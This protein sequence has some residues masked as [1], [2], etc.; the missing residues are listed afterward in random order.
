MISSL[1]EDFIKEKRYL[2]NL[3]ER[4]LTSYRT[5]MFRRWIRHVGGM[6][7]Q[8]GINQFVIKMREEGLAISTC[9]ITIRSLNS[10]LS[11]LHRNDH[12]PQNLKVKQ[13]KQERRIMKTFTEAQ[14]K[15]L[16]SWKPGKNRNEIRLH[17]LMCLLADTGIRINEALTLRL[18][19][20]DWDNLLIKVMGKG[21]KERIVPISIELRKVLHRYVTKQ[22]VCKHLSPYLLCASTGTQLTYQN[23][24]RIFRTLMKSLGIEGVDSAFHAFRR[25]FGKNYLKNGGNLVYL[26]RLFGHANITTTKMYVEDIDI[27]DLHRTHMRSSPLARL[28]S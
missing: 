7:T 22:R 17:V 25:F 20:I 21:S 28:K 4:T 14:M 11:W 12:I 6:P 27:E 26:Q 24:G 5:D 23:I 16:L 8:A 15:M 3:S 19:N 10:F 13:L 18:E 1:F 9:N 2:N